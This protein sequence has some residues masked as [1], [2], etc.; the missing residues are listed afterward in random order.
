MHDHI[1]VYIAITCEHNQKSRF[2]STTEDKTSWP[3]KNTEPVNPQIE[4]K[5]ECK[6]GKHRSKLIALKANPWTSIRQ[7]KR[8]PSHQSS[9]LLSNFYFVPTEEFSYLS[10]SPISPRNP[11]H[12]SLHSTYKWPMHLLLGT[13][14]RHKL[15]N[16]DVRVQPIDP[17]E[18]SKDL[19]WV[20]IEELVDQSMFDTTWERGKKLPIWIAIKCLEGLKICQDVLGWSTSCMCKSVLRMQVLIKGNLR[21]G[22][23]SSEWKRLSAWDTSNPWPNKWWCKAENHVLK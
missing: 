15:H 6:G 21:T 18:L 12:L 7:A 19:N 4:L 20:P 1:K 3:W 5:G 2:A 14:L 10:E 9:P 8:L 22:R 11:L 16:H 13:Y 17:T 23:Y